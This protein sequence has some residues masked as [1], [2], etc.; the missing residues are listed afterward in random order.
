MMTG[1]SLNHTA[2]GHP[3]HRGGRKTVGGAKLLLV[4]I[5]AW[6]DTLPGGL[7]LCLHP[8]QI[9]ERDMTKI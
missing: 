9:L 3:G 8:L 6:P 4:L 7:G 1:S 5:P 2:L